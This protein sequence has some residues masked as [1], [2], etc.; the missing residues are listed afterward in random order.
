MDEFIIWAHRG[1]SADAPENTLAAFALAEAQGADGIEFDVQLSADGVPV[2]IHDATL[3]RTTDGRGKVAAT[4]WPELSRLDAGSWFAPQFAGE[5]LPSLEQVLVWAGDRLR[6]N[7]EFKDPAAASSLLEL[8]Q[9][10]PAS[11]VLVSSFDHALLEQLRAA[12]PGLA[13]GF[14]SESR[15]WRRHLERARRCGAVSF[16]PRLDRVSRPLLAACRSMGLAVFPWTLD[17]LS[18]AR[19]LRRL[20]I[21]GLFTN[22]PGKM[23]VLTRERPI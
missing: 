7:L 1:A 15:F 11:R 16:H 8:L 10:F 12:A 22:L 18:P 2:V 20:G 5:G 9:R 17:E 3:Q 4:A 21:A 23:A 14:L 6:L 19:R 13:I